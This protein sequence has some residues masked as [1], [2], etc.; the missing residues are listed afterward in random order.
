[1]KGEAESGRRQGVPDSSEAGG[2]CGE[3]DPLR[4][5]CC[6]VLGCSVVGAWEG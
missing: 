6:C 5:W 1:M 4:P 2:S 3:K